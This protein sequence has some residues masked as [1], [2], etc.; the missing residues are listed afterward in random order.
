MEHPDTAQFKPALQ[1][2][3]RS[4]QDVISQAKQTVGDM[5]SLPVDSV[6]RCNANDDG[7]WT[8][9]IDVIE[10]AARMGDNDL[11]ASYEVQFDQQVS[12]THFNRLRRYHRE[13]R[14]QA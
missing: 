7:T 8:V 14:D 1:T 13:D 4:M 5:T 10:S 9:V 6:A 11:L 2:A 3:A 12:L